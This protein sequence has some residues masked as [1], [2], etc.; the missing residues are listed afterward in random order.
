M[1]FV[2]EGIDG[3]G[4]T[5]AARN[6]VDM[7]NK[8]GIV[9]M[10]TKEPTDSFYGMMARRCGPGKDGR[11]MFRR[12]RRHHMDST[13]NPADTFGVSLVCDRYLHSGIAYSDMNEC[14]LS[15]EEVMKALEDEQ[16]FGVR[17][18][19]MTFIIDIDVETA[20][21]RIR[22]R[23]GKTDSF[24]SEE[25]L[26]LAWKRYLVMTGDKFCH[27]DGESRGELGISMQIFK[28]ISNM[29]MSSPPC[30]TLR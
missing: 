27:I 13:I 30:F 20:A 26:W 5:T 17:I 12:D 19:D 8:S 7:L 21:S 23:S 11:E 2:I 1:F 24:E 18:P 14:G 28:V 22:G 16:R 15:R 29:V 9:A 6:V 10:Y 25:I 3:S 4:K